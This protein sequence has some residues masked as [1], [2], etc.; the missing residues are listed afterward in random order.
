MIK[1]GADLPDSMVARTVINKDNKFDDVNWIQA[2]RLAMLK[3]NSDKALDSVNLETIINHGL[4]FFDAKSTGGVFVIVIAGDKIETPVSKV[5]ELA[6]KLR[7][8]NIKLNLIVFPFDSKD[9]RITASEVL[10]TAAHITNG[11]VT[12]VKRD[13][14]PWTASHFLKAF[15]SLTN[16][17]QT[18][19]EKYIDDQT[20]EIDF[21]FAV[22][23]SLHEAHLRVYFMRLDTRVNTDPLQDTI[24]LVT[25]GSVTKVNYADTMGYIQGFSV[26]IGSSDQIGK[27]HLTAKRKADSPGKSL[28]PLLAIAEFETKS[29]NNNDNPIT[30]QCWL[31]TVEYNPKEVGNKPVMA[32]VNVNR[33]VDELVSGVTV[34]LI[35]VSEFDNQP[36]T[37]P[38]LVD[39]GLGDPDITKGDGIYSTYVTDIGT[40]AYFT[41]SAEITSDTDSI[42]VTKE[43]GSTSLPI[44]STAKTCCGSRVDGTRESVPSQTKLVRRVECGTLYVTDTFVA[45]EYPPSAVR[46]LR[47]E[48]AEYDNRTVNLLWTSPGGDYTA[49]FVN[50]YDIKAFVQKDNY[51]DDQKLLEDIRSDF[52]KTDGAD[53]DVSVDTLADGYGK[54][55]RSQIRINS[56]A[57]GVYYLAFRAFDADKHPSVVSNIVMAF[58]KIGNGSDEWLLA[59]MTWWEIMLIAIGVAV[60]LIVV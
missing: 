6:T 9:N 19:A 36:K 26:T 50:K 28:E 47:I 18:I 46:D 10:K 17:F 11:R 48:S 41:I 34:K 30:G 4:T 12:Y 37:G 55:Q 13:D 58:I 33:K 21:E 52:E 14:T 57:G 15:T 16:N 38:E 25:P 8:K 24:Q 1:Y 7:N 2:S 23:N 35:I 56:N 53:I 40:Q 51:K 45:S 3:L 49:G 59:G 39:D 54:P 31:N 20:P 27:W 43:F 5:V 44:K 32:Y 22:D 60:V 29:L 42:E